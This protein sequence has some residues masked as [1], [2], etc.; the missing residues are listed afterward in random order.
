MKEQRDNNL[1]ASG[2]FVIPED[3]YNEDWREK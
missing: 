1:N 3:T 2:S